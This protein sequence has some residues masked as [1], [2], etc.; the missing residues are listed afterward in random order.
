MNCLAEKSKNVSDVLANAVKQRFQHLHDHVVGIKQKAEKRVDKIKKSLLEMK[1]K[2]ERKHGFLLKVAHKINEFA[3][4]CMGTMENLNKKCDTVFKSCDTGSKKRSVRKTQL[5]FKPSIDSS[6]HEPY[7]QTQKKQKGFFHNSSKEVSAVSSFSL[8]KADSLFRATRGYALSSVFNSS[9]VNFNEEI[10]RETRDIHQEFDESIPHHIYY[11][12]K[13]QYIAHPHK[14]TLHTG[15]VFHVRSRRNIFELIHCLFKSIF[16]IILR[17]MCDI[18]FNSVRF[19]CKIPKLITN[20]I[21]SIVMKKF[22]Y[23]E[24]TIKKNTW[25]EMDANLTFQRDVIAVR[26]AKKAA[27]DLKKRFQ[28]RLTINVSPFF[29]VS[30]SEYLK[31]ISL[32]LVYFTTSKYMSCYKKDS[33]FDNIYIDTHLL[34]YDARAISSIFPLKQADA[35]KYVVISQRRLTEHE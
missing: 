10:G 18:I 34:K 7:Q 35:A 17:P 4:K 28:D 22:Y 13:S 12:N 24:K 31:I 2:V 20:F 5:T 19:L 1:S 15:K 23:L 16:S 27:E 29:L 30:I 21:T 32:I 11:Y 14:E 6:I 26:S 3:N 33:N 9:T 25:I 8:D